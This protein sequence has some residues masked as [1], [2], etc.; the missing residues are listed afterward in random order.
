MRQGVRGVL[1]KESFMC[2]EKRIKHGWNRAR[3]YDFG[4][5]AN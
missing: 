3:N 4:S 5:E 2:F 1:T